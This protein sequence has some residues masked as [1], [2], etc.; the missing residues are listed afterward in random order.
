MTK[1]PNPQGK[2]T[3]GVLATLDGQR[4]G[5]AGV[6]AKPND[7][8]ATELFTSLFVLEAHFRFKPVP[9]KT[10]FLYRQ[11]EHFQLCLSPPA[12]LSEAVGRRFIGVC[13]LQRDMTWTVEL[14]P[15][16]AEDPD[17]QAYL[18]EQRAAFE[19]RLGGA[20]S[21]DDM[22]PNYERRFSFHRRASA[23]GVAYSLRRSMAQA[24]IAGLSYDQA[25][26]LLDAPERDD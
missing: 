10:C 12:M 14:A 23:F 26:G 25:R 7:Q 2:G 1:N 11:A 13:D 21:V 15:A 18:A 16:V 19:Q 22:L 20:E 6:P 3:P 8:V 17:F 5:L 24:G 4:G 9:G